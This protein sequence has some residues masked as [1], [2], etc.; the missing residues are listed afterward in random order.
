MTEK[1]IFQKIID[2]DLPCYKVWEDN[3]YLAFLDIMPIQA[4]HTLL[5]PKK[6]I[7][8]IFDMTDE[9]YKNIMFAAKKVAKILKLATGAY[10]IGMIVE[11]LEVPHVHIKLIPIDMEHSLGTKSGVAT[12]EELKNMQNQILKVQKTQK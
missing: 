9:E 8:Y 7:D 12:Q 1:N 10:K 2:G 6:S 4:G 3:D 11:G 5:I